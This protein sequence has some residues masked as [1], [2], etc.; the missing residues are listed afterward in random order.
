MKK[1]L[2]LGMSLL[3]VLAMIVSASAETAVQAVTLSDW[4]NNSGWMSFAELAQDDAL[5]EAWEAGAKVFGPML[6]IEDLDGP[7]LRALN[8]QMC[9]MEDGIVSLAF[10]EDSISAMNANGGVVFSYQYALVDTLENAIEGEPLYVFK[11]EDNAAGKYTYLCLT[12]PAKASDEGGI[13]TN[14]NLRYAEDNYKMLA[15]EDYAGVT[16]VMVSG[17][18]TVEDMEYTI[19]LI[20][21][22]SAE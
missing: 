10:S 17:E 14:F 5:T 11:T 16:C 15:I 4:A 6:G 9:G 1:V 20:Y 21:T 3:L 13:I 19:R 8:A 7:T 12:L 22:G 18:T 2:I